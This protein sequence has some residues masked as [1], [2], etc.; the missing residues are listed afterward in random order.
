[1]PLF[2]GIVG[3]NLSGPAMRFREKN[4]KRGSEEVIG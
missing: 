4:R 2:V 1:V 3:S